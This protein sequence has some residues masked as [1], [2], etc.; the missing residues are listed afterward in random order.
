MVYYYQLY[1]TIES[2]YRVLERSEKILIYIQIRYLLF[3]TPPN[4]RL[5][6]FFFIYRHRC[7]KIID[8]CMNTNWQINIVLE[9][10]DCQFKQYL[11]I[12]GYYNIQPRIYP[13]KILHKITKKNFKYY[14]SK[15]F[16]N[17]ITYCT[18]CINWNSSKY[19]QILKK[20]YSI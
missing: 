2:F 18:K 4:A 1:S 10:I 5:L 15:C 14:G 6:W 3:I 11:I 7:H 19:S 17:H 8:L 20:K 16:Q 9:L 12:S 13:A